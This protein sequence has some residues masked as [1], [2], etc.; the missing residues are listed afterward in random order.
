MSVIFPWCDECKNLYSNENMYC[1]KA[2]PEGIPNKY[3]FKIDVRLLN[4]CNNGIKFE[5]K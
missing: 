4:E 1:C 2:F 3:L 5:G